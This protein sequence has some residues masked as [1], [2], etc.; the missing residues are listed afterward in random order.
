MLLYWRFWQISVVHEWLSRNDNYYEYRYFFN[1]IKRSIL[2]FHQTTF[3]ELN[4]NWNTIQKCHLLSINFRRFKQILLYW[5]YPISVV[6][7]CR[8]GRMDDSIL[9][10]LFFL[11]TINNILTFNLSLLH[12]SWSIINTH[13]QLTESHR[14]PIP[15]ALQ[16][17]HHHHKPRPPDDSFLLSIHQWIGT[18]VSATDHPTDHLH[19]TFTKQCNAMISFC[20]TDRQAPAITLLSTYSRQKHKRRKNKSCI[21]CLQNNTF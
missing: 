9:I 15:I 6:K 12:N 16:S 14:L 13:V 17:G 21:K 2:G 20:I 3:D 18:T 11:I 5:K 8:T 4:W 19:H 10:A 1:T 7:W